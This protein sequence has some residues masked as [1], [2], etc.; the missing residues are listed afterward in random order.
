MKSVIYKFDP[1]IYPFQLIV[2]KKFDSQE[3]KDKFY[4]VLNHTDCSE[5]G[6]DLDPE[7]TRVATTFVVTDKETNNLYFMVLLYQPNLVRTGE[8]THESEHV[9]TA[10]CYHLGINPPEMGND[11]PHAYFQGWVA[12]CIDSVLK[13]DPIKDYNAKLLK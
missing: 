1:V 10:N 12:N 9:C 5:F 3:L 7:P 13:G 2:S 8:I 6:Q 4:I 11:E